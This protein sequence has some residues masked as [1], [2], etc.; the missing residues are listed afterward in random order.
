[1]APFYFLSFSL[2][3]WRLSWGWCSRRVLLRWCGPPRRPFPR[4]CKSRTAAAPSSS[5]PRPSHSPRSPSHTP[6]KWASAVFAPYPPAQ[7]P[8]AAPAT[9][10]DPEGT[11]AGWISTARGWPG[12]RRAVPSARDD[13]WKMRGNSHPPKL[14]N[15]KQTGWRL[16]F[17]EQAVL[18]QSINQSINRPLGHQ[19][20]NRSINQ[21]INQSM[22]RWAANQSIINQ[23]INQSINRPLDRR[24]NLINP[25]NQGTEQLCHSRP[26]SCEPGLVCT[27]HFYW[28]ISCRTNH[29][30]DL[31][32][33]VLRSYCKTKNS[34]LLV[35]IS[36]P[37]PISASVCSSSGDKLRGIPFRQT[38][39]SSFGVSCV[40]HLAKFLQKKANKMAGR[41]KMMIAQKN[42]AFS[43]WF[44]SSCQ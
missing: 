40:W 6:A 25:I 8:S 30:W 35:P 31:K 34:F 22:D 26:N 7:D 3:E 21:S 42:S 2:K 33:D 1:M 44:L 28:V 32:L 11:A 20:S 19:I 5:W 24:I 23:S 39:S 9:R 43:L 14:T 16:Q 10:T 4:V 12:R 13:R 17:V 41:L 38:I 29:S 15:K 27:V 36:S 37:C 18:N